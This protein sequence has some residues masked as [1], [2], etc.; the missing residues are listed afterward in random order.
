M[1]YVT[2]TIENFKNLAETMDVVLFGSGEYCMRFLNRIGDFTDKVKYILDNGENPNNKLYGIPIVAPDTL[3]DMDPLHT[4]A[5]ITAE[6]DIVKLYEQIQ[7]MGDF[8]IMVQKLMM[9]DIF[10]IVSETL[11]KNRHHIKTVSDLLYDDKSRKIYHEVIKRRILFG[12]CDFS[13]LIVK[14]EREYRIPFLY[15]ENKPKDE[16]ILDCGAYKGDTLKSFIHT[17]GPTLK[18][19][20]SFECMEDSLCELENT[21]SCMRHKKY[22]PEIVIMPYALSDH[23]DVMSFMKISNQPA[24]SHLMESKNYA[25]SIHSEGNYV[26]VNVKTIDSLIPEDEKVTYI[27]MDIEGGEYEAILGAKHVIQKNKPKLAIS[28]YHNGE[29]YYRLPL[30]IK[31]LVPEYKIAIRHHKKIHVDTDMYCWC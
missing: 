31:K 17:F 30:L 20:Y 12:T 13:D 23:E 14:G 24:A 27:K 8:T 19:I 15:S 28:I 26:K 2:Q 6:D 16:V 29:D 1:Q 3:K 22:A 11:Y 7:K 10:P 5:V 4:L 9:H 21:A 18:R 25:K